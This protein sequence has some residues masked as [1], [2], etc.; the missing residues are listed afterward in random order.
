MV[1]LP[2]EANTAF[3]ASM[4]RAVVRDDGSVRLVDL[5]TGKVTLKLDGAGGA[6]TNPF[7]GLPGLMSLS[8]DGNVVA[9][10]S[11]DQ[12][13]RA[14]NL[15]T[16][17][18]INAGKDLQFGDRQGR[19]MLYAIGASPDGASVAVQL[20]TIELT[21]LPGG[22]VTQQAKYMVRLYDL[23]SG[24]ALWESS[25]SITGQCRSLNFS[26]DGRNLAVING[27]NATI[28]VLESTTGKERW[29]TSLGNVMALTFSAD[30]RFLA[31]SNFDGVVKVLDV[32]GN[33]EIA[34]FQ[35]PSGRVRSL[36]FAQEG[37]S[38]I[39]GGGDGTALVWTI[40][41]QV[42]KARQPVE[43]DAEA[44]KRLWAELAD[45]DAA[46]AF[47]AVASL[48]AS[49]KTAVPWLKEQLKPIKGEDN[50]Q[51]E[52]MIADLD[53]DEF[54]ARQKAFDGLAKLEG[55]AEV[56][57]KKALKDSPSL[58]VRKHI[59]EL[60]GK[61]TPG[62]VTR[63]AESVRQT[64][65]IEVLESLGSPEAREALEA[66]AKGAAGTD[67]TK[68]AAAALKRLGTQK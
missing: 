21:L 43:V 52:K 34:S 27:D 62:Q 19:Q 59:E 13:V 61:L 35:A 49:S 55:Q 8:P 11:S 25:N 16:G 36:A 30:S 44:V 37:T 64:R 57:L 50:S 24:A 4:S 40:R 33:K 3:L 46:K 56:A 67:L 45:G 5:K 66:L 23:D 65:A 58:E 12:A 7:T 51:I 17:K 6:G 14:F 54:E 32:R 47:R 53:S 26:P 15:E 31:A 9:T 29:R 38:L 39:T 42:Q 28:M 60:L 63:S 48:S 22:G 20:Y 18:Q 2:G 68:D 41:D 10:S 1:E